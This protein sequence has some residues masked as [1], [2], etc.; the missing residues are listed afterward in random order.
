MMN[1]VGG[2]TIHW[3]GRY[4]RYLPLE[5]QDAERGDQELGRRARSRP[6][7]TV[8]DWPITY[9]DLEPYYDKAEY[10]HGVSG[11]A[12]NIKG[13]IDQRGNVFEGARSREF[14]NPPLRET[15]WMRLMR[16]GREGPRLAP[17]PGPAGISSRAYKG[18]P[19]CEYHGFCTRLR[20][21]RGREGRAR[22]LNGI[23]EA[24]KTGKPAR[25]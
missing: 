13:T 6:G 9:E 4:W 19:A 18:L 8:A 17:V 12:G 25:S 23:P 2:T 20:L 15:G 14:P 5:L 22:E 11:K 21:P 10:L 24:E 7:S 16:D 1:A 3:T